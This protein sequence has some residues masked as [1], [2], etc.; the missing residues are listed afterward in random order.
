LARFTAQ[1]AVWLRQELDLI[2]AEEKLDNMD[3]PM[4]ITRLAAKYPVFVHYIA[5]H[6]LDVDTLEDLS[7]ARN[8][9]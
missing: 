9:T 8:F 3:M 5:G 1:G 4:L 7:N 2:Q 6:W